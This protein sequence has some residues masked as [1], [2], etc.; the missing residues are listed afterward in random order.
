MGRKKV[1]GEWEATETIGG[2]ITNALTVLDKLRQE[3][4]QWE[5]EMDRK[6]RISKTL[7][8]LPSV[9]VDVRWC[10]GVLEHEYD[11]LIMLA[12]NKLPDTIHQLPMTFKEYRRPH[13]SRRHQLQSAILRLLLIYK[14]VKD[15]REKNPDKVRG[16]ERSVEWALNDLP[17]IMRALDSIN[18]PTG[19][20]KK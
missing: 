8:P 15:F 1:W 2:A 14:T 12:I 13:P 5:A 11:N 18:F 7:G 17:K 6:F 9:F 16:S 19:Y 4:G 20:A 10:H 3:M